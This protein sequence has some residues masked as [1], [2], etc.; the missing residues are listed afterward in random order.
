[1]LNSL[2]TGLFSNSVVSITTGGFCAA[3]GSALLLGLLIA[4]VYTY[5][6]V[7]TKSFLVTLATLPAIVS[8]I[9]MMV[10]GSLGAGVAVAGTFSLVR[11][12]SAPGTAREIGVIFLAMA[13]GLA[14]GM[15]YPGFAALFAVIMCLVLLLYTKLDFG[16]P[17]NAGLHKTLS[18]TMPEALDYSSVFDDLFAQYTVQAKLLRVK[19]TNLGSLNRLTYDIL[20]KPEASEKKFIDDLRCR[21]GN[22]E[23]CSS[24]QVADSRDL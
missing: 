5:K 12:R 7:Y 4:V 18:I 23:I 10:S 9:I 21:N 3:M 2:F 17:K 24:V 8:V 20:L 16:E 19:T 15:G 13:I 14:C 1:M 6:T 22:L 11:F